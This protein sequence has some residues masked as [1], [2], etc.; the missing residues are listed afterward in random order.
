MEAF[1]Q[2]GGRLLE[3][4][5]R[6]PKAPRPWIDLSTGVN[7]RAFPAAPAS[8]EARGRLPH[9]ED[10]RRLEATAARVFGAD[11]AR[12][13]ATPGAEAALR[14][15]PLLLGARDIA[16]PG[17]TYAS[18][19]QAWA[20]AGAAVRAPDAEAEAA[21]IVNPN[22]PDGAY[23]APCDVLALAERRRWLIVDESFADA[24]PEVSVAGEAR[25]GLIVLRSFG[26]FY[27]LAGLRLGFVI[28]APEVT[29]K[30]RAVLGDWPVSADAIAAGTAAYADAAWATRARLRLQ[31]DAAR[32]DGLLTAASYRIEGGTPLFRLARTDDAAGRF[33]QLAR[34]GML[35]RPFSQAPDLLRFGLPPAYAWRRLR[36]ALEPAQMRETVAP[37]PNV[38]AP[39]RGEC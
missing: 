7:P 18:H 2:H 39:H 25:P 33:A 19:A 34:H 22:N 21:L 28:A 31:R 9:P 13:V 32:L 10:L 36:R 17:F 38:M 26:K 3:A 15:L 24:T 4:Q 5:A 14:L 30:V 35:V 8:R 16:L 37:A 6:W 29:A 11:P 20:A 12:V 1:L 23:L 27:G